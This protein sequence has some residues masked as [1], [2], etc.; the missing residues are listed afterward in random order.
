M[1]TVAFFMTAGI[2]SLGTMTRFT[3]PWISAIFWPLRSKI[4]VSWPSCWARMAS[5]LGR[6]RETATIVPLTRPT[7]AITAKIAR[8][9][10][11]RPQCMWGRRVARR[12]RLRVVGGVSARSVMGPSLLYRTRAA[13]WWWPCAGA[14][15]APPPRP[16]SRPGDRSLRSSGGGRRRTVVVVGRLPLVDRPAALDHPGNEQRALVEDLERDEH[17]DEREGVLAGRGHHGDDGVDH[18]RVAPVLAQEARRD[19]AHAHGGDDHHRGFEDC[20]EGDQEPGH[21]R[22]VVGRSRLRVEVLAVEAEEPGE[23]PGKDDEVAEHDAEQE[24][25]HAGED[26][27]Q[28]RA[29]AGGAEGRP[30]EGPELVDDHR[31]GHDDAHVHPHLEAD[32][33]GF[34]R[35][36][37]GDL[38]GSSGRQRAQR[39]EQQRE[40]VVVEDGGDD[41]PD[42]QRDGRVD[43]ATAQLVEVLDERDSFVKVDHVAVSRRTC[44]PATRRSSS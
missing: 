22:E 27:E 21:E 15:H 24:E 30:H 11:S 8:H 43:D 9:S 3:A 13:L 44:G 25:P 36:E 42:S 5:M 28:D 40:D 16:S 32:H 12:L 41:H 7:T 2:W 39:V 23:S 14:R 10:T 26:H 4:T 38:M 33:E 6:L 34:G 1:A 37:G 35:A 29:P 20:S 17:G 19:D 18:D 31:R